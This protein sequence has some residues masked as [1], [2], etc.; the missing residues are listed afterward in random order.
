MHWDEL[1]NA[2]TKYKI[3]YP[4]GLQNY[5]LISALACLKFSMNN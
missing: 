4:N 3:K 2:F 1:L 5:F